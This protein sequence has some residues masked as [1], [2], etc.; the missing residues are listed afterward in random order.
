MPI[1]RWVLGEACRQ[2]R[3]W[4]LAAAGGV[5]PTM[6][7]NVSARQ[8]QDPGFIND[9]VSVLRETDFPADRLILEITESVLATLGR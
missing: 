7:V 4:R 6:S 8:L 2:G 9:V 1:G 3:A 5:A